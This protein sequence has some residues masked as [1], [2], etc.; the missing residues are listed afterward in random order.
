ME[1]D[2]FTKV[3]LGLMEQYNFLAEQLAETA[4]NIV[5]HNRD[6]HTGDPLPDL[7]DDTYTSD[8]LAGLEALDRKLV[9]VVTNIKKVTAV[10]EKLGRDDVLAKMEGKQGIYLPDISWIRALKKYYGIELKSVP[11]G[12][13][14][15]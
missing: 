10:L 15:L 6:Y 2:K 13:D 5:V 14:L 1:Q 3:A 12:V 4:Q 7:K 11:K 8:E 9:A